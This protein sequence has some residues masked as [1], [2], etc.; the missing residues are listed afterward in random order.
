MAESQ[1]CAHEGCFCEV[2]EN[3]EYC[4]EHCSKAAA[5]GQD[6]ACACGHEAC[7]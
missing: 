3:E 4:S 5:E 2:P 7:G 1:L 6:E